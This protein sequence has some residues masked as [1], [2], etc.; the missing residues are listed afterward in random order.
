MAVD[1]QPV[2]DRLA[3][4]PLREAADTY[5]L[6]FY[7]MGTDCKIVYR[8]ANWAAAERFRELAL[9]WLARFEEAYSRFRPGSLISRINA[10]AGREP[11][12]I[13]AET[14][15]LF[16]LCDWFHWSTHA[17]FDP[18]T[19]PV[20][21]LWD[22]HQSKPVL[23]TEAQLKQALSLVGWKRVRREAGSVF[24]PEPGMALDL[25]GIGKEYAVD[26]VMAMALEQGFADVLVDFG[27]DLRVHGHPPEGGAWRIGLEKADDPGRC[28][29]GVAVTD[30][31]VCTSGDYL[32][33]VVIDGRTYGHVLDP[34][35]GYPVAHGVRSVAV[36]APT[37]TE[38]GMLATAGLIMGP[39]EGLSFLESYYQA[40][41]CL[42][43]QDGTRLTT[44]RF[45][46]YVI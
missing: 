13:D 14:E 36:I 21:R 40:E 41:G 20:L 6:Q 11:V 31:A 15:S 18:T 9:R 24:L 16:A 30:R 46:D 39:Q 34:R 17:V 4:T 29:S 19:L 43:L 42:T 3:P 37:C 26:C 28:W 27:H 38:A 25:G 33:H 22:Y 35:T 45:M 2:W 5:H 12:A 23:P 44:R 10:A 32:R 8:A 1:L 7:A